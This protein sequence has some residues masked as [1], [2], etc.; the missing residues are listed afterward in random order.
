MTPTPWRRAPRAARVENGVVISATG[1][2]GVRYRR[3][4]ELDRRCRRREGGALT[5]LAGMLAE[6][7]GRPPRRLSHGHPRSAAPARTPDA[8]AVSRAAPRA[9]GARVLLPTLPP[10]R[11]QGP[12]TCGTSCRGHAGPRAGPGR[13]FA[14]FPADLCASRSSARVRRTAWCWTR[15][16]APAQ[17]CS[18]PRSWAG[19]RS[20]STSRRSNLT[21]AGERLRARRR[22]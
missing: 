4:I 17:R 21:L 3:Q 20:A 16:A 5:A 18:W 22:G 1:V 2:R 7:G 19:G 8:V 14:P 10:A 11:Q 13:H 6:V 12:A 15:S 9:R